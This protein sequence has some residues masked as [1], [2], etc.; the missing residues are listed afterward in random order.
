MKAI[1]LHVMCDSI[2]PGRRFCKAIQSESCTAVHASPV[3]SQ[4]GQQSACLIEACWP[5]GSKLLPQHFG[6]L[7]QWPMALEPLWNLLSAVHNGEANDWDGLW[8][9]YLLPCS[10]RLQRAMVRMSHRG[11]VFCPRY[12]SFHDPPAE[13]STS[14]RSFPVA[15]DEGLSTQ[16]SSGAIPE[17]SLGNS[18]STLE[19]AASS[20]VEEGRA[21]PDLSNPANLAS[22]QAEQQTAHSALPE[23]SRAMVDAEL[24]AQQLQPESSAPS[25]E[26]TEPLA[27]DQSA[28]AQEEP[29]RSVPAA[30]SNSLP[31]APAGGASSVAAHSV[32]ITEQSALGHST[33]EYMSGSTD[34]SR[35]QSAIAAPAQA[36]QNGQ[37]PAAGPSSTAGAPALMRERLAEPWAGLLPFLQDLGLPILDKSY[38]HLAHVCALEQP[39]EQD[40]IVHKLLQCRKAGLLDVRHHFH[41]PLS[42][43]RNPAVYC[44]SHHDCS[45]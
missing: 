32:S 17:L 38:G 3:G 24:P 27:A 43:S 29:G 26:P 20:A 41:A 23:Q 2:Y 7:L 16:R 33:P 30:A 5:E 13:C 11:L 9:W 6:C 42:R 18:S 35:P 21:G 40:S 8:G 39:S 19:G 15:V 31:S 25:A 4:H 22:Q 1:R 12:E 36:A 14:P 44:H 45:A 28:G 37:M 34:N 10:S